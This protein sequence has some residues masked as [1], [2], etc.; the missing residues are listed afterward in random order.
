MRSKDLQQL[1]KE[2]EC[3]G[4]MVVPTSKGHYKW[5]SPL[6]D[7]F[8]SASTP[9]DHRVIKNIQRDLTRHGFIKI[10]KKGKKNH[11]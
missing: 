10:Q 8:F 7:F 1:I 4:W 6:G 3:Q 5:L 11:G 9:S 2:A